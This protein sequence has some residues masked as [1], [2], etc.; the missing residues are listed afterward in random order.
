[1]S[2]ILVPALRAAGITAFALGL[3]FLLVDPPSFAGLGG[4][5]SILAGAALFILVTAALV[6]LATGKEMPEP[7]FRK[8]VDR[9]EALATLPA[10]DYPPSEFDL[11]VM[12]A[13]DG[14]PA[15]F[16]EVLD[17][18]PVVISHLGA[19]HR[20]YGHYMGGT[21]ANDAWPARIVIYQDTL[22]RDFGH[23]PE[24]LR[25]QVERTVRHE[26]AHHLGWGE[27]G[28]RSLGL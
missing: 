11:L 26:V 21:V 25:A 2:E 3:V 12:E 22:E 27:S 24:L 15:E 28:V 17:R 20:A 4:M 19:E 14:L 13:L 16:Q 8:L 6:V 5:L 10:P 23:H 9:S 1:M 7:E 18:T